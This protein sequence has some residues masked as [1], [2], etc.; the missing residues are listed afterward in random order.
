MWKQKKQPWCCIAA[1]FGLQKYNWTGWWHV[2]F[3]E[4]VLFSPKPDSSLFSYYSQTFIWSLVLTC[5]SGQTVNIQARVYLIYWWTGN[6][7]TVISSDIQHH[8]TRNFLMPVSKMN[9]MKESKYFDRPLVAGCSVGHKSR[10]FHATV[11]FF[12]FMELLGSS[13]NGEVFIFSDNLVLISCL[14]L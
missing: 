1:C 11:K 5:T 6:S 13:S 10:P 9:T 4:D 7:S 12:H 3:A 14:M 2:M 8:S